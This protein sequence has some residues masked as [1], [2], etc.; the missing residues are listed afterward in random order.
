MRFLVSDLK[1]RFLIS[2]PSYLLPIH[3]IST[4]FISSRWNISL[5][6]LQTHNHYTTKYPESLFHNIFHCNITFLDVILWLMFLPTSPTPP[7]LAPDYYLHRGKNCMSVF[8]PWGLDQC[9]A[10][11]GYD[12]QHSA[13]LT[14]LEAGAHVWPI[15]S[16]QREV[17]KGNSLGD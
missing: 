10:H 1:F 6:S 7:N 2:V 15:V 14:S 12:I 11:R 13:Y 4:D 16:T 8:C 17:I 9:S 3:Q 5:S